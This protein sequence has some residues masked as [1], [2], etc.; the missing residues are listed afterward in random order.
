MSK[1]RFFECQHSGTAVELLFEGEGQLTCCGE[2]MKELV[3]GTTDAAKEK[4]VPAVT[5][6]GN[7]VK[8]Q[9]GTVKHPMAEDHYIPFIAVVQGN[10]VQR[11][12]LK[13]GEEP[14][15]TFTVDDGPVEVYE[16][17]NKHGLWMTEA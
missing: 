13:P 15:A 14:V 16:Y 10:K 2:P 4:H 9:V 12:N 11:V 3:A 8:V 5:R 7:V 6:E 1:F 17:C